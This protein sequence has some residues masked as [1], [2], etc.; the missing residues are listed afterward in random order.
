MSKRHVNKV[1]F[2]LVKFLFSFM[3][4]FFSF[5]VV[6][7]NAKRRPS[8]NIAV[9]KKCHFNFEA[10]P[11]LSYTPPPNAVSFCTKSQ[12]LDQDLA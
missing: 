2:L 3:S 7:F 6:W 4:F 8:V 1:K 5:L 9:T 10:E 12:S 11:Q